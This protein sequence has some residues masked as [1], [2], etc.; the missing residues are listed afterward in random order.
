MLLF[1]GR[2]CL[3]TCKCGVGKAA[4]FSVVVQCWHRGDLYSVQQC[5]AAGS[6]AHPPGGPRVLPRTLRDVRLHC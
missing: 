2:K 5:R 3:N 4:A 6:V 1:V